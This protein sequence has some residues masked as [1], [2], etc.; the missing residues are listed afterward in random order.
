MMVANRWLE[1]TRPMNARMVLTALIAALLATPGARPQDFRKEQ[2]QAMGVLRQFEGNWRKEF[3]LIQ[4]TGGS[5]TVARTGT[6]ECRQALGGA[7]MQ[8]TGHDSDGTSYLSVSTYDPAERVFKLSVFQSSGVVS[9]MTGAYDPR[10]RSLTWT[11]KGGEGVITTATYE[12]ESA[13]E[14]RFLIVAKREGALELFR[15]EGKAT[16]S[17]SN[18]K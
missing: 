18:R 6:H 14:V 3:R 1:G 10:N 8:E 17:G 7:V 4:G 9:H 2:Q 5:A 12:I 13:N 11:H 15:L 16:K